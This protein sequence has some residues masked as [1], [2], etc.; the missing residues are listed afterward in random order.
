MKVCITRITAA[1]ALLILSNQ[2]FKV[3]LTQS[4]KSP[5]APQVVVSWIFS[6]K[7]KIKFL[8]F[9]HFY[10]NKPNFQLY[11]LSL[12]KIFGRLFVASSDK[13]KHSSTGKIH[14]L[15]W[16]QTLIIKTPPLEDR[17]NLFIHLNKLPKAV[18]LKNENG[19]RCPKSTTGEFCNCI[20]SVN[21][22]VEQNWC[23]RL[24]NKW[25]T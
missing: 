20:S 5:A 15:N 12:E 11:G 7:A 1:N 13:F 25:K 21:F 10:A 2:Y 8:R 19:T 14:E 6:L 9:S 3:S 17:N 18:A 4:T 22:H 16:G 24:L 23:A